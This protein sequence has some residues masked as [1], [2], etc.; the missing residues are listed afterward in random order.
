[1]QPHNINGEDGLTL[2]KSWKPLLTHTQRKK[3][4]IRNYMFIDTCSEKR[5][6]PSITCFSNKTCPFPTPL[7]LIGSSQL[8]AKYFPYLYPSTQILGSTST[9]YAYQDGTDRK[10][11]NVGTKSSDAGILL[12]NTIRHSTHSG[13]LKS[14]LIFMLLCLWP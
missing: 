5:P 4:A 3:E 7:P 10:F 2:S 13:S 9:L 6:L 8:W 1:M 12:K 14:R 11:R